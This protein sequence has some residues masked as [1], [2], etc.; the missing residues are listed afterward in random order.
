VSF[1][2]KIKS[3][4]RSA[5][6]EDLIAGIPGIQKQGKDFERDT[7]TLAKAALKA[8]NEHSDKLAKMRT[9]GAADYDDARRNFDLA[10]GQLARLTVDYVNFSDAYIK[11][12]LN[13]LDI[14]EQLEKFGK[15]EKDAKK[16]K[17]INDGVKDLGVVMG[18]ANKVLDKGFKTS[19]EKAVKEEKANVTAAQQRFD[20]KIGKVEALVGMMTVQMK[21]CNKY[22]SEIKKLSETIV[23]LCD[24]TEMKKALEALALL[25]ERKTKFDG[26]AKD[27]GNFQAKL[28]TLGKDEGWESTKADAV[29]E[30]LPRQK[31]EFN[32]AEN[33]YDNY[34]KSL[35][36][37]IAT[38]TGA[39]RDLK[40]A[41]GV[42]GK[43]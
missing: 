19:L 42:A 30:Y 23:K 38:A 4:L 36:K 5:T 31:K 10:I 37:I 33:E 25:N 12:N 32:L 9:C 13:V 35:P 16:L 27:L 1:I 8:L 11:F 18:D 15:K 28:K 24:K 40:H 22:A 14:Q 17:A 34:V 43:K 39:I 29:V 26:L 20:L 21:N 6:P 7:L 41:A 2:D 3:K